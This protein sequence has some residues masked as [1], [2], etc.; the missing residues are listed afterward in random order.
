MDL[1]EPVR[2]CLELVT[3]ARI[4]VQERAEVLRRQIA[5]ERC[6]RDISPERLP[7][8]RGCSV[9]PSLA[10]LWQSSDTE[11]SINQGFFDF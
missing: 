1:P 10:E 3:I 5:H 7:V 11:A 9:L 6:V 8:A 4:Q 2:H